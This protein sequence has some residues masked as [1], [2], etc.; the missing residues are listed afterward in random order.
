[1][2][3]STWTWC[4]VQTVTAGLFLE[5]GHNS[6]SLKPI[7]FLS[8]HGISYCHIMSYCPTI[9][10]YSDLFKF[11]SKF[12]YSNIY[13][14]SSFVSLCSCKY[15]SDASCEIFFFPFCLFLLEL[16]KADDSQNLPCFCQFCST[17]SSI[18]QYMSTWISS[19][20]LVFSPWW[21]HLKFLVFLL[22]PVN[23]TLLSSVLWE[24]SVSPYPAWLTMCPCTA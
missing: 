16:S 15:L 14:N 7:W 19:Y 17:Q 6:A 5:L 2:A 11:P 12:L 8:S 18:S 3:S 22:F 1:M 10:P 9:L 4:S 13:F 24:F 23:S 20:Y 21:K